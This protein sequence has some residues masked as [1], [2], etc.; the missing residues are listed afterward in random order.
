MVAESVCGKPGARALFVIALKAPPLGAEVA[1]VRLHVSGSEPDSVTT[2]GVSSGVDMETALA[3]GGSSTQEMVTVAVAGAE[4]RR[5]SGA[6]Y[7]NEPSLGEQTLVA[8]VKVAVQAP[9]LIM[10]VPLASLAGTRAQVRGLVS[11]SEQLRGKGALTVLSMVRADA[12][13]QAG[14]SLTQVRLMTTVALG[15]AAAPSPTV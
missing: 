11:T 9:P 4:A 15:E 10:A 6:G 2:T 5:P 3:V 13:L 1:K 8:G 7:W 12:P 14:A